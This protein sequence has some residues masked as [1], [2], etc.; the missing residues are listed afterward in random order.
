MS[1]IESI[2]PLWDTT[3]RQTNASIIKPYSPPKISKTIFN[4]VNIEWA[5]QVDEEKKYPASRIW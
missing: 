4:S 5:V 1:C 2:D 3:H